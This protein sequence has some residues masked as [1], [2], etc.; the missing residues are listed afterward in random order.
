MKYNVVIVGG[1][2]AGCVLASRLAADPATSVLLL[3]A[4]PDYAD[5]AHL[6]DDVKAV[7]DRNVTAGVRLQRLDQ[8]QANTRLRTELAARGLRFTTPDPTPF[9]K[10]LDAVYGKWKEQLGSRCWTLLQSVS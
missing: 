1:G 5:P 2:A 4:G 10:R 9:K 7:I 6:P 8:I 3:E